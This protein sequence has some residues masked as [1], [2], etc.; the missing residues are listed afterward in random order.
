MGLGQFPDVAVEMM[1]T[2]P[3]AN[4]LLH[5]C[6]SD[7]LKVHPQC[8]L[9]AINLFHHLGTKPIPTM[10]FSG[11]TFTVSNSQHIPHWVKVKENIVQWANS[12]H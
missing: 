10:A 7:P 12:S 1:V 2:R 4:R 9:K 3:D 6:L 5:H 8:R 11:C